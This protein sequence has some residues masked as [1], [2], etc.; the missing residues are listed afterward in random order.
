MIVLDIETSGL[1]PYKASILSIGAIDF[2][3]PSEFF[4][5]ECRVDDNAVID[6]E[7]LKVAGFTIQQVTDSSKDSTES[8]IKD[9]IR[10]LSDRNDRTI[11]GQN[12]H[13]DV[14]FLRVTCARLGINY[15]FGQRIVDLHS[16]AYSKFLELGLQI[17]LDRNRTALDLDRILDFVGLPMRPSNHHALED[18]RL[19]AEAFSRIIFGHNL[20]PVYKSYPV[21]V[22]LRKDS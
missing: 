5:G 12:V 6:P 2:S 20:L 18:A 15:P 17:P 14:G 16:V 9:L 8:L 13:W 21:P 11:A 19:E 4:Y 3:Q 22:Y 10:W 1:D 7:S